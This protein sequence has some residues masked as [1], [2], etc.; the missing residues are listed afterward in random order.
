MRAARVRGR[1]APHLSRDEALLLVTNRAPVTFAR[2]GTR[3]RFDRGAGGVVTALSNLSRATPVTWI[4]ATAG[5][6]DREVAAAQRERGGRLGGGRFAL[7]LVNIPSALYADFYGAFCN[8]ILWFVQHRLWSDRI[9]PEP[10]QRVRA[11]AERYVEATRVF[12]EAVRFEAHRPEREVAVMSHDYQ[13]YALPGL[14]SERLPG[15][16]MVHFVH[17]PWPALEVWRE[18]LP[19]D[20]VAMLVRGLLGAQAVGF[21]DERSRQA[22]LAAVDALAPGAAVS[23]DTVAHRGRRTVV[24]V[25]PVSLDPRDLHPNEARARALHG[26]PRALIVRVDRVDPIKN[27]PRGFAAFAR[28]LE[29]R[30]DLVGTVRFVARIVPSRVALPEYAREWEASLAGAAAL[31][32]RYG[33]GTVEVVRRSDRGRALA[34]LQTADVVLVNSVADGMNLVAKETAVL[35]ARGVLVLST[36]TG[37]YPELSAGAIAIDPLDV[38]GTADALARAIDMPEAERR[39]RA[40]TMRDA[41]LRWTAHDWMRALLTDLT[42]AAEQVAAR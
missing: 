27:V 11:L 29:R 28:L 17:I 2:E 25:R 4:A 5:T 41:V 36:A 1:G 12:A 31:N 20:V 40:A 21:Q 32:A 15:L 23:G 6:E 24:R 22:F 7:R 34:E 39:T 30:P 8:R 19:D 10:P 26:D 14:V 37:A 13:L 38:E 42:D 9:D 3:L 16:P 35:N 33:E 18:A